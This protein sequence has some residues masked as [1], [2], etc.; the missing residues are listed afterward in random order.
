MTYI[1]Q[2]LATSQKLSYRQKQ[3]HS[4]YHTTYDSGSNLGN[5]FCRLAA[6]CGGGGEGKHVSQAIDIKV[7]VDLVVGCAWSRR[8]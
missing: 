6:H 3:K 7:V 8:Y 4:S 2:I 5:R 1:W